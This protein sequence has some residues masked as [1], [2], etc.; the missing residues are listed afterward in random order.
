MNF[1]IKI[2]LSIRKSK[3]IIIILLFVP[4]FMK[5]KVMRKFDGSLSFFFL[6]NLETFYFK[7]F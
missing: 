7:M 2:S 3:I 6:L 4:T 1:E 5:H